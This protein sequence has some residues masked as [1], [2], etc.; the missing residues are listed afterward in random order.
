MYD[1]DGNGFVG[2]DEFKFS[3]R[4]RSKL[5]Q[6]SLSM[7][8]S[9]MVANCF[10]PLV[11]RACRHELSSNTDSQD[12]TFGTVACSDCKIFRPMENNKFP[13]VSSNM[14]SSGNSKFAIDPLLFLRQVSER[15]LEVVCEGLMEGCK[16]ILNERIA[17]LN[18][19]YVALEKQKLKCKSQECPQRIFW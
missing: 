19:A 16:H 13:S 9:D 14:E 4:R 3:V 7:P 6:W 18:D 1:Q 8:F 15:D 12:Y 17:R 11:L 10:V 5:E 2:L